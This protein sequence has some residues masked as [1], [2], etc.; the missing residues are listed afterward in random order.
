VNAEIE[1]AVLV[2]SYQRPWHLERV[3]LSLACQRRIHGR[4]EVVV[5]DDGSRDETA[6][7]VRRFAASADF[8]IAMT[9][10]PHDGFQL[11]RCRNEGVFASRAPYLLFL[12]GDCLVPPDHLYQHLRHRRP[13]VVMG[14]YCC[15]LDQATTERIGRDEVMSGQFCEWAAPA[16]RKKLARMARRARLYRWLRHPTKPKLYG[17]NVGIFRADYE[18]LNGYDEN[19]RGWGCEDDDL[20]LRIR[21]AKM[22][23]RSILGSTCT[24]HLWHPRGETTPERWREGANVAYLRRKVRPSRCENGLAQ[25]TSGERRVQLERLRPADGAME[26]ESTFRPASLSASRIGL[27]PIARSA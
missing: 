22:Q 17:G 24:Y 21:A 27:D 14:G 20:R 26:L 23:V 2:S 3:L 5:T 25:Y 11:A 1:I 18:R 16:E 7:T 12:D 19:F 9:T 13:G 8:P 6:E 10:H 15:L 4:F